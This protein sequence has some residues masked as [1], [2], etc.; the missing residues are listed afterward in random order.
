MGASD[1]DAPA[2]GTDSG[3]ASAQ[4]ASPFPQSKSTETNQMIP[5]TETHAEPHRTGHRWL[6]IGI[7][8][9]AIFISLTSLGVAIHHG[10]TMERMAEEN[11]R[12]V[13]ANSWPFLQ[14]YTSTALLPQNLGRLDMPAPGEDFLAWYVVNGGV[15]PAKIEMA[16]FL[17]DGQPVR[18]MREV[19]NSCCGRGDA[20]ENGPADRIMT[21]DLQG[22]VLRA[23]ETI[24]LLLV[25]RT[26]HNEGI[27]KELRDIYP[28]R[29]KLRVCYCS[30]FDECWLSDLQTL[31][32]ER[33]QQCPAPGAAA[34]SD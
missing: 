26:P 27:W 7:A 16:E 3:R 5:E 17:W 29:L 18:S 11:A 6:D 1:H 9:C 34:A 33:V 20:P 15:G 19:L 22:L 12:L 30:V 14:F 13:S 10:R 24:P 31:R 2:Q 25:T 28:S 4:A 8:L 23:G 32:P 21:S